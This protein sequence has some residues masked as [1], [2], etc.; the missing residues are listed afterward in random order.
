MMTPQLA[1]KRKMESSDDLSFPLPCIL[2]EPALNICYFI[3]RLDDSWQVVE[4]IQKREVELD[5]EKK[6]EFF[7]QYDCKLFSMYFLTT[8]PFT[9]HVTRN[10]AYSNN[11]NGIK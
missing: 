2:Q 1:D 9:L 8:Y 3:K 6:K 5:S 10:K 7:I 11:K 4:V